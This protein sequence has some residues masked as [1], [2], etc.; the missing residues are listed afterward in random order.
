MPHGYHGKI[1]HVD[2]TMGKLEVEEPDE[3]FYRKYMGGS[4]MSVYYLLKHTPPGADPLGPENTLSLMVGV[5]TGAPFSGQSRVAATAKSPVWGV[6]AGGTQGRRFRWH[7]DPRPGRKARLPVG[8]RWGG[9]TSG[10]RPSLGTFHCRRGGRHL[11]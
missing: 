5:V 4:A 8:A 2:L 11:G 3:T 9:G 6:L 10:R 7:R 1:L